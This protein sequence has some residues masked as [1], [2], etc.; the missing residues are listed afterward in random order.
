MFLYGTARPLVQ[1]ML[2]VGLC[3]TSAGC[4]DNAEHQT[5]NAANEEIKGLKAQI[6]AKDAA[7]ENLTAE[8]AR[9]KGELDGLTKRM[10]GEGTERLEALKKSHS[11]ELLAVKETF[12]LRQSDLENR[13][14]D[15][16]VQLRLSEQERMSLRTLVDQ[17][18][19]LAAIDRV[20]SSMERVVWVIVVVGCL[21]LSGIFA[22][23]YY[24]LRGERRQAVVSMI[25]HYAGR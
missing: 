20:N 6:A 14:G 4:E 23:G 24:K 15:T 17:P 8:V 16:Q 1:T 9:L 2:T 13:L 5:A 21:A 10:S 19:R 7:N 22:G 12:R 18:E 11:D 25:A 3:V